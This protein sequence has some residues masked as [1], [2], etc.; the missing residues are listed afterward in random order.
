MDSNSIEIAPDPP[1]PAYLTIPFNDESVL[2]RRCLSVAEL[3]R[4]E[5]LN[6][7]W[8]PRNGTS[9]QVW[10]DSPP[11]DVC[12]T[13]LLGCAVPQ[14]GTVRQ[15]LLEVRQLT[16]TPQ[17]FSRVAVLSC[18]TVL[19]KRLP[20]WVLSFWDRLSEAYDTCLSWRRCLDWANALCTRRAVNQHLAS[21]LYSLFQRV[22]WYGYLGGKRRDRHVN[23][24]FD[25]LSNNEL[26][27]GQIGDLLELIEQRLEDASDSHYLIAPPDLSTLIL[28][29]HRDHAKRTYRK[30]PCQQLV[31]EE[32]VQRRWFAVA[33][34]AWISVGGRG[35]W[36]SYIADP[37][38]STIFHGDS[39]GLR[40]P[41]DLCDALQWWLCDLR[42][43]M[44]E[45]PKLPCLKPISVTGQED[46]FSCGILS[47]NSLLHH[48]LP[49][50]FPLVSRDAISIA[51][52]RIGHT[53]D[54]LKLGIK[55]VRAFS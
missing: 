14:W 41:E 8:A 3:L 31:E 4:Y 17:S 21:E 27:S 6:P 9:I 33:S 34:I 35:H 10:S 28:Y 53:I 24:I 30:Q 38:T 23:D 29:S 52:Y 2:P 39:L 32:L 1:M 54:I 22:C 40:I 18:E 19:P 37:I 55:P 46:G 42:K 25:L 48:L 15:L 43:R 5:F 50:K 36:I 16:S 7:F 51:T 13:L 47:T 44:G 20:I 26:D 12:A 49:Y 45:P 11:H